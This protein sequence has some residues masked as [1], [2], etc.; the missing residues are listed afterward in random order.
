MPHFNEEQQQKQQRQ[1]QQKNGLSGMTVAIPGPNQTSRG[2]HS[3]AEASPTQN[4]LRKQVEEKRMKKEAEKRR[5]KELELADE[6]RVRREQAEI[7]NAF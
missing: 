3:R 6:R 2:I 1:Q 5:L 4:D 7:R